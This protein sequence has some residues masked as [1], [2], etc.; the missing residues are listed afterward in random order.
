MGMLGDPSLA[1]V[2]ANLIFVDGSING[3]EGNAVLID[4]GSPVVLIDGDPGV[5]PGLQLPDTQQVTVNFS[6]L[7]SGGAPVVTVDNIP[8]IQLTTAMMDANQGFAAILGGDVLRQFSVQLDYAAPMMDGFCLGCA[9]GPRGDVESPGAAIPFKIAGGGLA[10]VEIGAGTQSGNVQIPPTRIPVTVFIEGTDAAHQYNF[11]LDTGAS[12]VT[13]SS[14]VYQ[15]LVADGRPQLAGGIPISTVNG[16]MTA[17]VTRAKTITVGG[18]TVMDAPV[19]TIPVDNSN[20]DLLGNLGQELGYQLDGLL[21]GSFLRNFLVTIDY[22]SGQLHLQ[23]Y[24]N[25]PIADEFRRVGITINL[26]DA[27]TNFLVTSVYP[28]SDAEAKQVAVNDQVL[29]IGQVRLDPVADQFDADNLLDGTPGTTIQI[30]FGKAMSPTI[31]NQTV[32]L[33]VDDLIPNPQ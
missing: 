7:D 31:S 14:T 22:P 11:M 19:M 5:F 32:G 18:E 2:L 9:S 15:A 29:A 33:L 3:S 6:F 12:E 1:V 30:Q 27:G 23:R 25:P 21:G 13:L 28:G 16:N 4:S 8:A 26:N 17:S 20:D 24:T 10:P